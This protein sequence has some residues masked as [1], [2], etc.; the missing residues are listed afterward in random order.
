MKVATDITVT[1]LAIALGCS[2]PIWIIL[3]ALAV[4]LRN[5]L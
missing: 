3:I 1:G 5:L 2:V 4:L